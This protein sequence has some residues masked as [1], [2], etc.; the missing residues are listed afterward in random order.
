MLLPARSPFRA[1]SCFTNWKREPFPR[2]EGIR[3]LKKLPRKVSTMSDG[4]VLAC[5]SCGQKNRIPPGRLGTR[6]NC[7]RCKG[8]V[9][10]P[11]AVVAIDRF[12]ELQ[13]VL[14]DAD[15]PVLIDFWAPWCGPCRSV[16]PE[17]ARVARGHASDVLVLKVNTDVDPAVGSHYGIQA[18]PTMAVFRGGRELAR[19][20]GARPANAIEAWLRQSL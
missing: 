17:V 3:T 8:V 16:A 19:A 13:A 6:A 11:G 4:L 7:G 1:F 2:R 18:I 10:E 5:A 9:H 12:D 20:S 15:V 14:R